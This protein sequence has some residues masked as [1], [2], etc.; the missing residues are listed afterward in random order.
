MESTLVMGIAFALMG[1][2]AHILKKAGIEKVGIIEYLSI[3]KGRTYTAMSA[4]VAAFVSLY[5]LN[6]D[7]TAM[8]FFAL[9]YM[10]DSIANKTP[11]QYEMEEFKARRAK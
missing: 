5:M 4:A 9:G 3:H 1:F 6:P 11:S 7:A 8:E 10:S 2:I